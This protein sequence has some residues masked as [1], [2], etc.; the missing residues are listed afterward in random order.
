MFAREREQPLAPPA[1]YRPRNAR[2]TPLYQLLEAYYEDVKAVWEE[3]FEKKFGF[4]R[5]FVDAVV[6]RYL[7]CGVAEAGFAR[8]EAAHRARFE[9]C[10]ALKPYQ[11]TVE[12]SSEHE[13]A[14]IAT[15]R[16]QLR[17]AETLE[18]LSQPTA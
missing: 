5:G 14:D 11:T 4:W 16:T 10:S 3:R 13:Y 17:L 9:R 6:A 1:L 15:G 7:D 18:P 8:V 2:A 12:G